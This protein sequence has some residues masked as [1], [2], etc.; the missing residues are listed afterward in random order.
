MR[1]KP[2]QL[3]LR[4]IA[5]S[6]AVLLMLLVT[7]FLGLLWSAARTLP[8]VR[9]SF[10]GSTNDPA[11]PLV[12]GVFEIVND[13]DEPLTSYGG[14][15]EKWD[16]QKWSDTV[17]SSIANFGG[18]RQYE[19]GTT[20]VVRTAL[21]RVQGRYRLA[22]RYYPKSMHTPK[23]YA[24]P[25]Y[26]LLQFFVRMGLISTRSHFG[27][28]VIRE[29]H[30]RIDPQNPLIIRLESLDVPTYEQARQGAVAQA[31]AQ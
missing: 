6:L 23:F 19:P 18:E 16:G 14:I 15:F 10:L 2:V 26:R 27:E 28:A 20:N 21:P 31:V 30:Y 9:V 5:F 29:G 17:G 12:W 24:S 4:R 22:F 25:R 8:P 1:D 3:K 11:V 7:V 13:L